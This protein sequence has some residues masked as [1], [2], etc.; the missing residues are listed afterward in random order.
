MLR[1]HSESNIAIYSS[2]V[3]HKS[4][5]FK[6]LRFLFHDKARLACDRFGAFP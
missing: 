1:I 4:F 2:A 5:I 3:L 6:C